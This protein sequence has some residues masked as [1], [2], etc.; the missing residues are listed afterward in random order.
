M[1]TTKRYTN[2]SFT[3]RVDHP[4]AASN[5]RPAKEPSICKSCGAIYANRRWSL[6]APAKKGKAQKWEPSQYTVC[7]ACV[8]KNVGVPGGFLFVDGAFW[9]AHR[10]EIE[11]L[12]Q[13]E[14]ARAAE[15]NPLAQIINWQAEGETKLTLTT[16]TE[17][18]AQRLGHA[19][20]KA[21]DGEVRYDFSHE[22]K[23]AR[24]WWHRDS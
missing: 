4:T 20:E 5:Q 1:R 17:H 6:E 21:F 15:T 16:T 12:L 18:L 3:K 24:V 9:Q 7:P 23:L 8:Q 10:Q 2:T 13:N 11:L 19:L 14:A 22:N